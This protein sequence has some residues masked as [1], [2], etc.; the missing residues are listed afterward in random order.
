MAVLDDS[1]RE[2]RA[3]HSLLTQLNT[4]IIRMVGLFD[5]LNC[6]SN[7]MVVDD[8]LF[9]ALLALH[10]SLQDKHES[11]RSTLNG[12]EDEFASFSEGEVAA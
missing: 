5:A 7:E 10:G 9:E 12:A 6:I 11:L 2:L 4:D 8:P 3:F 1:T